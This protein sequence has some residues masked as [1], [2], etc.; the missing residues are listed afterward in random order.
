[1]SAKFLDLFH[2][3]PFVNSDFPIVASSIEMTVAEFQSQHPSSQ[4]FNKLLMGKLLHERGI[5]YGASGSN[6]LRS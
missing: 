2:L 5:T 6:E 1:M 4:A 3:G